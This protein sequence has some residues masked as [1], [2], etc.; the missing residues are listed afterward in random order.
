MPFNVNL[1]RLFKNDAV[2]EGGLLRPSFNGG[3]FKPKSD[4]LGLCLSERRGCVRRRCEGGG[5][6]ITLK[7]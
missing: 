2:S 5:A 4:R 7:R 3:D 6:Q 1:G